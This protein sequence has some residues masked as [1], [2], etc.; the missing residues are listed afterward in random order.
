MIDIKID[1]GKISRGSM[2][3]TTS[4]LVADVATI[5]HIIHDKM[6][7]EDEELG[8]Y[9]IS[10]LI[11]TLIEVAKGN[12]PFDDEEEEKETELTMEDVVNF[13]AFMKEVVKKK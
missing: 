2:V 4:E 5:T 12:L 1:K 13:E 8:A 7:N 10:T 9:C 6:K 3:G 11:G